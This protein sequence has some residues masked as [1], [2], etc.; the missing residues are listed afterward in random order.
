VF[1]L[2]DAS[3][4]CADASNLP[5]APLA[6]SDSSGHYELVLHPGFAEPNPGTLSIDTWQLAHGS[7]VRARR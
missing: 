3:F 6:F 7:A 5:A 2:A 1:A 4:A